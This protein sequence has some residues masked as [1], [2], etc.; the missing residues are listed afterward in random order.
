[1]RSPAMRGAGGSACTW[2][3]TI[4]YPMNECGMHGFDDGNCIEV[5]HKNHVSSESAAESSCTVVMAMWKA[6]CITPEDIVMVKT[7]ADE[8][9]DES[10]K[11]ERRCESGWSCK[12]D[13]WATDGHE[14]ASTLT[15]HDWVITAG[16]CRGYSPSDDDSG[17]EDSDGAPG[18]GP[19]DVRCVRVW[20]LTKPSVPLLRLQQ[21]KS[22]KIGIIDLPRNYVEVDLLRRATDL[23]ISLSSTPIVKG[24][25]DQ[26][27][28]PP[29][30]YMLS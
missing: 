10:S 4:I 24:N 3:K 27:V 17:E 26:P 30:M 19:Y 23:L 1:M 20:D 25:I 9:Y 16:F 13:L 22:A 21:L 5:L 8:V 6:G 11:G 12:G 2:G 7:A 18:T 15:M 29:V 28:P 14:Q